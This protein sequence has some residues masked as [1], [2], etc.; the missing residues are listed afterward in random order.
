M[1][2][3]LRYNV[4]ASLLPFH[5]FSFTSLSLSIHGFFSMP[6]IPN[7]STISLAI[8][9]EKIGISL[10]HDNHI[11]LNFHPNRSIKRRTLETLSLSLVKQSLSSHK[12]VSSFTQLTCQVL[13]FPQ[14]ASPSLSFPLITLL[15]HEKKIFILF[16]G[17]YC[18]K[19]WSN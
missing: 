6:K 15:S 2:P 9:I 4:S 3:F 10:S 7:S 5:S 11:P 8:G 12:H 14:S 13:F 17:F 18:P 16:Q 19:Q 1:H